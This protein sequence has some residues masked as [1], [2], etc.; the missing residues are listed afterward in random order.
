MPA[1]FYKDMPID[2]YHDYSDIKKHGLDDFVLSK[3]MLS[4]MTKP[5]YFKW[6]YIDG[7]RDKE[8]KSLRMGQA[9]HMVALEPSEYDRRFYI[10]PDTY[11]D[12]KGDRKPFRKDPRM[13]EYKNQMAIAGDRTII[14][15]DES[16]KILGMAES[17]T[18]HRAALSVLGYAGYV[19]S[20]IFWEADGLKKRCRPDL[21]SNNGLISDLKTC[22]DASP[23]G[24]AKDAW[25]LHYDLSV[26]LTTE[27][28]EAYQGT[29]PEDY[30]FV[31]VENEAPYSVAVYSAYSVDDSMGYSY[32][33]VGRIRAE[34]LTFAL[35]EALRKNE[36]LSGYPKI[37]AP[38]KIP[39]YAA[40]EIGQ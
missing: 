23:D 4:D 29:K 22:R 34:R 7:N 5:D 37:I 28:F 3:S 19:E 24:F 13:E 26:A 18:K 33:D 11:V 21:M 1:Q 32:L 38:M 35:K 31:C 20:S 27:G 25:N 6:K 10:L 16:I 9:V 40:K 36:W 2:E 8:T 12:K 17:L 14:T 39:Y 15:K 30:L